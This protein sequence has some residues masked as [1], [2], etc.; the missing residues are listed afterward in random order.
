M[1]HASHHTMGRILALAFAVAVVLFGVFAT[2]A[3]ANPDNG[4]ICSDCHR[5]VGAAPTVQ[6]VSTGVDSVTYSVHQTSDAWAAF[7][8]SNNS[9]RIAG[10]GGIDSTFTAPLG[11]YVR[12]C[13]SN[14][15]ATGTFTQAYFVTPRAP[16]HGSTSPSIPRSSHREVAARNSRSPPMPA[17]T[18]PT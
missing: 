18:S 12:V 11:H 7:D 8:L 5:S 2:T 10:D 16:N 6:M 1:N 14:G 15:S 13:S 4:G 9:H 3:A 17:I